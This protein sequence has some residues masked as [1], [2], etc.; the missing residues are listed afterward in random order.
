MDRK[1]IIIIAVFAIAA[2]AIFAYSQF[3]Q[4]QADTSV[5]EENG[6]LNTFINF[7]PRANGSS[8]MVDQ[9]YLKDSQG[10]PIAKANVSATYKSNGQDKTIL[11]TTDDEGCSKNVISGMDGDSKEITYKYDGN[12]KYNGCEEKHTI[13]K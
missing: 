5:K 2:I 7:T 11:V 4:P 8:E 10:N 9:F 1:L 3:S 12:D 13:G 6:K